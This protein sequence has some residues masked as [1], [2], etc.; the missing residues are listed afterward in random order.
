[1]IGNIVDDVLAQSSCIVTEGSKVSVFGSSSSSTSEQIDKN[2]F[3][4]TGITY[5][6]ISSTKNTH[7]QEKESQEKIISSHCTHTEQVFPPYKDELHNFDNSLDNFNPICVDSQTDITTNGSIPIDCTIELSRAEDTENHGDKD[8]TQCRSKSNNE[9]MS[10][11][12]KDTVTTLNRDVSSDCEQFVVD[13]VLIP[14]Y[15]SKHDFV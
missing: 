12:N 5:V 6:E 3:S 13:E 1:M 10:T 4:A 2:N 15:S 11:N 7:R 8:E 9:E 14:G